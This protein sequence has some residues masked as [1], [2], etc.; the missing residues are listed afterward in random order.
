MKKHG[1]IVAILS[2]FIAGFLAGTA[3]TIWKMDSL[4]PIHQTAD[5]ADKQSP[6][7]QIVALKKHLQNN[8]G[9]GAAWGHLGNLYYDNEQPEKAIEAYQHA[10]QSGSATANLL[11]DLGVM[12]RKTKQPEKAIDCFDKAIEKDPDHL[13]SRFNKGVVLLNDFGKPRAAIAV[14]RELLAIDP[15]AATGTGQK[16]VDIIASVE[17]DIALKE[18]TEERQ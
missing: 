2:V 1:A 9:D 17:D 10:L 12:Y 4:H 6:A 3:F 18:Q 7:R 11:T 8:P 13:P 15:N 5:S 14:W 16:I